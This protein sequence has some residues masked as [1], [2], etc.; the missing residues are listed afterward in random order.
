MKWLYNR[1]VKTFDRWFGIEEEKPQQKQSIN[2]TFSVVAFED[3][4]PKL[5]WIFNKGGQQ[6]F[7]ILECGIHFIQFSAKKDDHKFTCELVGNIYK[8]K[9]D[10]IQKEKLKQIAQKGFDFDKSIGNYFKDYT[11][12][13]EKEL[14]IAILDLFLFFHDIFEIPQSATKELKVNLE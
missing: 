6:N 5:V 11:F 3:F 13:T 4:Y 9:K 14:K 8:N 1:I 10:Q 2:K 7:A 12:K